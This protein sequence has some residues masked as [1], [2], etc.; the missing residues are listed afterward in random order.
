MLA[1][2]K[3]FPFEEAVQIRRKCKNRDIVLTNGCF[4][5]LH[6]G[7]VFSLQQAARF[8]ELWVALNGDA[9]IHRLKGPQRPVIGERERAY[10]LAA[11]EC[12]RGIF[13]FDGPRLARELEIF[14]PDIYVKSSDYTRE[15]LDLEEYSA[16]KKIDARIEFVPRLPNFS[17]SQII[18]KIQQL[19]A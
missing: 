6:A 11:L 19:N 16:L 2:P 12:V 7:H 4:D 18:K 8:G 10:M 13:I 3:L 17:T 14:R 5:L 1:N 9:S 15:T